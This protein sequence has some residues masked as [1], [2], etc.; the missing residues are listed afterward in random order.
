MADEAPGRRGMRDVEGSGDGGFVCWGG[1]QQ[2]AGGAALSGPLGIISHLLGALCEQSTTVFI[3]RP[4]AAFTVCCLLTVGLG[5][6]YSLRTPEWPVCSPAHAGTAI[7]HRCCRR[8]PSSW[9]GMP[10]GIEE[11]EAMCAKAMYL[12]VSMATATSARVPLA[13][14]GTSR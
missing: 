12:C 8:R 14:E 11:Q 1:R 7:T 4:H 2:R 3:A 9:L 6:C 10:A 5:S 13:G